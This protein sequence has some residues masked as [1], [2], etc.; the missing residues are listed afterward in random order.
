MR[1]ER[2]YVVSRLKSEPLF[3]FAQCEKD[4]GPQIQIPQA[5]TPPLFA[6]S[7]VTRPLKSVVERK[8]P[9]RCHPTGWVYYV[10]W[11]EAVAVFGDSLD[12][13]EGESIVVARRYA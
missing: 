9:A 4:T 6:G 12:D 5:I 7:P 1:K 8:S 13:R 10:M 2:L 11:V 3:C